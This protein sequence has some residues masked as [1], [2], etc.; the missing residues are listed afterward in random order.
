M[1]AS[2]PHRIAGVAGHG[3]ELH[4]QLPY[5]ILRARDY[6]FIDDP[7]VSAGMDDLSSLLECV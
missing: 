7:C 3:C 1:I 5:M 4:V 2:A 6:F